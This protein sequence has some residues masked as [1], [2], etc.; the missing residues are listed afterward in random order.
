MHICVA[1][2]NS[3]HDQPN[4]HDN[5]LH[6]HCHFENISSFMARV[7]MS[8]I[9]NFLRPSDWQEFTFV[10]SN[11]NIGPFIYAKD[12]FCFMAKNSSRTV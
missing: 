9:W 10:I 2:I 11:L 8:R 12:W 1:V 6:L 7:E 3:H 5:M 4:N